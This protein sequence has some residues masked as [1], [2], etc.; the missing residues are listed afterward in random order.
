M[1]DQKRLRGPNI[2]TVIAAAAKRGLRM[3]GATVRPGGEIDLK[4]TPQGDSAEPPAGNPW[5]QDLART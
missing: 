5:D 1:S 4:F 2:A 3:T